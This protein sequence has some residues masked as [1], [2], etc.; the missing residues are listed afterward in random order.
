MLTQDDVIVRSIS[1]ILHDFKVRFNHKRIVTFAAYL[2]Y[3]YFT[4]YNI[5]RGTR[6]PSLELL[7]DLSNKLDIPTFVF[8]LDENDEYQKE[9]RDRY[10]TK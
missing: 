8:L 7:K 9:I 3:N 6:V 2:G 5:M 4:I 1:K 10:L